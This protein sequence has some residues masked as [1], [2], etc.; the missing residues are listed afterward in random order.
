MTPEI[1]EF[2]YGFAFTHELILLGG[3]PLRAAPIFPTQIEE[4]RA[5]G[6]YDVNLDF[7]GFPL[8]IQFKRAD[9]MTTGNAKELKAGLPLHKPFY[10]MKIT[11]KSRSA[12]HELLLQLD[13]QENE[14][15]YVSPR[16]HS[17]RQ[18][19]RAYL[20]QDVTDRSFCIRPR[21]IGTLDDQAHHISY[22]ETRHFL[23]SDD[24]KEVRAISGSELPSVLAARLSKET[25][26]FRE[27]TLDKSLEKIEGI[28]RDTKIDA[29]P[30]RYRLEGSDPNK[31][32]EK[33]KLQRLA[34]L[35]LGYFSTQLFIV[36]ARR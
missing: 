31:S 22:D 5:G 17:V 11:E 9:F 14:V 16:F 35:A 21:D 2:S 13:V 25:S 34:D 23:C 29:H 26:P 20:G 30:G 33:E 32:A 4:G 28:L 27:S 24:P 3:S 8:F 10:R 12:Q 15:F 1:S 19:T 6:G 7:P 18:L 36:Q